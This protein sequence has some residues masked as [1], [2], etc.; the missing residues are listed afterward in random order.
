M[1]IKSFPDY[2]HLLQQNYSTW[3]TNIL[4]LNTTQEVFFTTHQYTSTCAPFVARRTSNR[5]S[6]SLHVFSNMSSVTVAK[7]SVILAFKFVISGT[8]VKNT[9]SLTYRHKKKSRRGGDIRRSW[10]SGCRTIYP[11]PPVWKCCIQ[12]P[13]VT[14]VTINTWHKSLETNLSNGKKN[15]CIPRSFLVINV[16]NQGKT[17]CSPCISCDLRM[18]QYKGRNMSSA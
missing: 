2:K 18:A 8:G 11:N 7:A 1:S 12:K 13:N 3:N 5:Q 16:C 6:I 17:L 14:N 9:L 10:W 15:V 4:F